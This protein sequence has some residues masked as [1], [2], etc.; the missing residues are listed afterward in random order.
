[1]MRC[2]YMTLK[3]EIENIITINFTM[4]FTMNDESLS[5]FKEQMKNQ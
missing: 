2:H 1:M 3:V 4:Y 5:N